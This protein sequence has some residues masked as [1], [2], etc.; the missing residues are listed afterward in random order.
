MRQGDDGLKIFNRENGILKVYVQ[1]RDI[2][3]L[4]SIPN[5]PVSIAEKKI[6]NL[7]SNQFVEFCGTYDISFFQQAD[8]IQDY[9][10]LQKVS[11]NEL[12]DMA[13]K[14]WNLIEEEKE[15]S[16]HP[17]MERFIRLEK[18]E[19]QLNDYY[20]VFA[21]K[22]GDKKIP[23][24]LVPDFSSDFSLRSDQYFLILRPGFDCDKLFVYRSNGEKLDRQSKISEAFINNG[25]ML[26]MMKKTDNDSFSCDYHMSLSDNGYLIIDLGSSKDYQMDVDNK[27]FKK[28]RNQ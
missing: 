12:R 28:N 10:Y 20:S 14:V 19:H 18:L 4:K 27:I 22:Q 21:H 5:T 26:A 16:L 3:L 8:F 9:R 23:F 6:D 2:K 24:P 25:V 13:H 1:V 11:V 7:D 17:N 15:N